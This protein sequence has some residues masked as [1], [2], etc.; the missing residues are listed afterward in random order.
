MAEG[1]NGTILGQVS[2]DVLA[3][4]PGNNAFTL[5]GLLA[6]SRETDLPVIGKF[7][8]AYLNGQTQTVKVFRNQSSV[9]KAIAMDLTISGLS[10]KANLDGIETKLIHQVNVLNFSIEFD[11]VHVNK[12]YVTGQLSVFFEL[13]SNIHMKF[14]ALRTSIN[15]TMHFNDKPSMGQMILHDLP[16]EHNQTTNELFISFN[17]QELIVLN[18]ASFKEFAA[19]L[20]LTT[21]ASIMI[22]GLAAALAEVRIGNITLSNI[23]IN[24][25]LHLVGYNEFDNGLLNID[26]I[27]LIGAISCQALALRVRTQIINPSVVNI[28]YGGRLSF[29]LCDIVSGKS[30]GLVNIDPF[31]LQLQDNIT[32]LDAEESVFV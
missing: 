3:I 15:F 16:V 11:L 18:D 6:P 13:P 27:D 10:M 21:N 4:R 12:V 30:L 20:V 19:N 8:S 29:D 9:K 1:E 22:E 7:F 31:Y 26:N 25:T 17:K 24:D 2:I 28:L 5:N 14:K 32:V 23:P